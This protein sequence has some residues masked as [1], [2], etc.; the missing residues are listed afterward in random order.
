MEQ[1]NTRGLGG[2][3]ALWAFYA[4]CGYFVWAMLRYLWVVSKIPSTPDLVMEGD[5]G[6]T[7]GKWLG[8]ILGFLVLGSVGLILGAIAWYTRPRGSNE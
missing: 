2:K 5:L 7:S 1:N 6:S 8:A 4:F 3:L